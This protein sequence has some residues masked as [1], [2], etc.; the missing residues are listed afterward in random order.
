MKSNRILIR[1]GSL[2]LVVLVGISGGCQN[3]KLWSTGGCCDD[4]NSACDM[5]MSGGTKV[6]KADSTF[7]GGIKPVYVLIP[8][9]KPKLLPSV[10]G[11]T[12]SKSATDERTVSTTSDEAKPAETTVKAKLAAEVKSE[13]KPS[14]DSKV[15]SEA[16]P[17]P[18]A[19]KSPFDEALDS[20]PESPNE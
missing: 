14:T 5:G 17:T 16:K 9:S 3:C 1:L 15:A 4:T 11:G 19:E 18:N 20:L 10:S 6:A 8:K 13:T 7:T 2:T 12:L